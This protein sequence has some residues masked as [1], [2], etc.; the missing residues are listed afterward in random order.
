MPDK[1]PV[2]VYGASGFSGRLIVEFLREY[3][4]PFVAAGRDRARLEDVLDRVPGIS[5]ADY[6]I[7][8][9]GHSVEEL[10]ALLQG[11][12]VVCNTVGP[13]IFYGDTVIEAALAAGCHY[14][15][16]GG[17]AP[18]VRRVRETWHDRFSNAGL[19]VAPATAYMSATAEAA[20]RVAQEHA[21]GIDTVEVLSMFMGM[22]TY[23]STQTI[24]GQL[25]WES[26]YLEQNEY[27]EW[28]PVTTI[29][30]VIPGEFRTRLALPWGG[31]PHPTWFKDDPRIANVYAFG[32]LLDRS[33]MENVVAGQRDYQEKIRPLPP[34]QQREILAGIADSVQAGTPPREN[35]RRQRTI[36]VVSARGSLDSIQVVVHGQGA[37]LQTGLIQAFAAHHL[38]FEAPRKVGF[39][40]P[41]SAFGHREILA[42][43]EAYGLARLKVVG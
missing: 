31:F 18:W 2:V 43:L 33:I 34:E 6:E 13:C 19:L 22:P 21:P 29:E 16:T 24:F 28:P 35:R 39:A 8:Q 15:D 40:S 30:A 5:T 23:G 4:V 9:V 27:V 38:V 26:F 14:V 11:A 1:R 41:C 20:I 25:Q 17:E 3:G 10:T 32:G 42:A 7:V 36:D 37:Y 12:K